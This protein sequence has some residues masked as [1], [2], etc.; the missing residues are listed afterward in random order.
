MYVYIANVL[1]ELL[2]VNVPPYGYLHILL[3]ELVC[4][5]VQV[6]QESLQIR[7]DTDTC[8]DS[9]MDLSTL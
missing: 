9:K 7:S 3:S 1:Y 4:I 8:L 6:Q 5:T 2:Y